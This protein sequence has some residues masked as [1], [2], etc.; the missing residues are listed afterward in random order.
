LDRIDSMRQTLPDRCA[1]P[2]KKAASGPVDR[3]VLSPEAPCGEPGPLLQSKIPETQEPEGADRG[4]GSIIEHHGKWPSHTWRVPGEFEKQ[5][6]VWLCWPTYDNKK[7][8]SVTPV[9]VELVKNLTPFVNVRICVTDSAQAAEVSQLLNRQ[10]IPMEKIAL[11]EIPHDEM[12]IRDFGPPFMVSGQGE[13]SVADFDFNF[14]G[15][16]ASTSP[17]SRKHEKVDRTIARQIEV[18]YR[19]TRLVG[20]QGDRE[21][22]GRGTMIAVESVELQRNSGMTRDEIEAELKHIFNLEKVLWLRQGIYEDDLTFK[23]TLPGPSG[24]KNA[25]TTLTTGG[26]VDEFC[27]FVSPDTILLA[28]VSEQEAKID[29]I[30][31]ENRRR[32]EENC[33]ILKNSVDQGGRPFRI[34]RIPMPVI[35]YDTMEPGDA[36]Y[37]YI[38]KLSYQDGSVFPKGRKVH[39]IPAASYLNFLISNDVVIA[40]KYW[41]P[42]LPEKV[43]QKDE[44]AHRILQEAFPG[45]KIVQV[46]AMPVNLG[47][48]GIH[49]ITSHEPSSP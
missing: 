20:E 31:C 39:V 25:Y 16:E 21:F 49:C 10:R 33:Q 3:Y 5:D 17:S 30:A 44:E 40:Q 7:D 24:L 48:G 41:K 11:H 4:A 15:Y 32:L 22:N 9:M 46:D 6:A 36:I 1:L 2:L 35:M 8:A 43:R 13:K 29:P 19:P 26:H 34:I 47:G 37:D 28:E 45:R 38:S 27:R 23:G 18:E 42:G 14:W 12:W